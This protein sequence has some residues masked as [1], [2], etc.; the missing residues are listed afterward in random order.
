LIALMMVFAIALNAHATWKIAQ[1]PNETL[2][3][4]QRP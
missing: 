4:S 3:T 1:I 2:L